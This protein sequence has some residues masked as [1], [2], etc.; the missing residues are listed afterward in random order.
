[1][2]GAS[3]A[4]GF[5]AAGYYCTS[6]SSNPRPLSSGQG[7]GKCT[8]GYTCA[9]G[10][11]AP[12]A[13]SAGKYCP[14]D[15]MA[16][17]GPSCYSGYYCTSAAT[18]PTP[19]DG[20][21]GNI[22]PTQSYCPTGS[23]TY[24]SCNIGYY[25]PYTGA[26]AST[27][28]LSCVPGYYCTGSTST[29][30][31]DCPAGYYCPG[32]DSSPSFECSRGYM[33]PQNSAQPVMCPAGT[34][35]PSFVQ[36]TC[37][38]CDAG[39]YCPLNAYAETLCPKGYYCPSGTQY[40]YQYPCPVGTYN[41]NIGAT[42]SASCSSCDKGKYCDQLGADSY[43]GLCDPGYY[44]TLSAQVSNPTDGT[45]GNICSAGYY[46]PQG[47][48]SPTNCDASM[49]CNQQALSDVSGACAAG[50]YCVL[51]AV[52]PVPTDGTTGN[53]CAAG[54]YCP[55]QSSSMSSCPQ[56]TYGP[57]TGLSSISNCLPCPYSQYCA[58]S[59]LS[60]PTGSCAL[61]YFCD[62]GSSSSTP[63]TGS[64]PIGY[65]CDSSSYFVAVPCF[66]GSYNPSLAQSS[67]TT[68]GAGY[69]CTGSTA[70]EVLCPKGYMCPA[71][72]RF[73]G[74]FPCGPGLYSDLLGNSACSTCP[75]GFQCNNAAQISNNLCPKYKYCPLGTG[76]GILCPAGTYN[77]DY[78]GLT[79]S[80]GCTACPA[81]QYC[82]DGTI[83]GQCAPGF[84]CISGSATATPVTTSATGEPC[85]AGYYCPK[86]TTTP[87]LCPEGY[88][89][90]YPG[91]Q[92]AT[93][94]T[95]CPP[96]NYCVSGITTPFACPTGNYCPLGV[97]APIPCPVRTYNDQ[98][99][100]DN[101]NF[102]KI[103]PPGYL[104]ST[105]GIST[106]TSHPCA[107]WYFC[108]QGATGKINC[109]PGTY[110]YAINA[111]STKDC[112]DCPGGFYCPANSTQII[113]CPLGT[114][115]PGGNDLYWPCPPGYICNPETSDP[116]PC[117]VDYYCPLYN[118]DNA[119]L[120]EP[121]L[122]CSNNTLCPGG[123][124]DEAI[125]NAGYYFLSG[126][127]EQC[128]PGY[129]SD[130]QTS[131]G[132]VICEEGYICTG[133]AVRKDPRS[134]SDGGYPC[135]T[136]NYC[137]LG[138]LAPIPCPLTTY[139]YLTTAYD[140]SS[141]IPCPNNAYG[142]S[143]GL[144]KCSP[145]G[146]HATSPEGS[147]NCTCVGMYRSWQQFDGSCFCIPT[148]DFF[149]NGA[150]VSD[151]DSGIDCFP[152]VYANC[153]PGQSRQADGT[154]MDAN[155]CETWCNG[156]AGTSGRSKRYLCV[157]RFSEPGQCV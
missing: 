153:Q 34:Y 55:S 120:N 150:L 102:C 130:G 71:G 117:P 131:K 99:G 138:A 11:S 66:M 46:C 7:G 60:A 54:Y 121:P 97:Q 45:T 115:C 90:E 157:Q 56:G 57:S 96:G 144:S 86:G 94:C 113:S 6:G 5:C 24:T 33:C 53:I 87:T 30:L 107:P 105:T 83:S 17:D 108:I 27:E 76:Y 95:T 137:P 47:S 149:Y 43:T 48:G 141:C 26:S 100:A 29:P 21:T 89:R 42:S 78:Q 16:L 22:C 69:Y 143:I 23:S 3:A 109:P 37:L 25:L 128:P 77:S 32:G 140:I 62:P 147:S 132:C 101:P 85:P 124:F 50:Y 36:S 39:Y 136:G 67:C 52:S 106:Y 12:V 1:M 122:E 18:S 104:C 151:V 41:S 156:A 75:A 112:L 51:N 111:G 81:G 40:A 14:D 125:C 2:K 129:Y 74:E 82:V 73:S 84:Y 35:Q 58:S 119:T 70:L 13:C 88:F 4:T 65:F 9:S 80:S 118:T 31:T 103:C 19:T 133:G 116:V 15:L 92:A 154:C 68:C 126:Y 64:C 10:S 148:Y 91:A 38:T 123:T 49:Y 63:I 59:A 127:C 134:T 44:C 20:T 152:V 98:T 61:G 139:N 93:D 8:M 28:C 79:A 155:T 146:A 142:I 110:T 145:C 114:Y 72:T 135:P